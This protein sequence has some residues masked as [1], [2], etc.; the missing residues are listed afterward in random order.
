VEY[1]LAGARVVGLGTFFAHRST[2]D[3]VRDTAAIWNGIQDYLNGESLESVVGAAHRKS[4][5][6][7]TRSH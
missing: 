5:M 4:S 6:E 2:S 3:I 7:M 1:F